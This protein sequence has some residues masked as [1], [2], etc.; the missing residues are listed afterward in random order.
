MDPGLEC[1]ILGGKNQLRYSL[2]ACWQP[3][4]LPITSEPLTTLIR[5]FKLNISSPAVDTCSSLHRGPT[6]HTR[7]K[8]V[9]HESSAE[10]TQSERISAVYTTL[11]RIDCITWMCI[12]RGKCS[13]TMILRFNRNHPWPTHRCDIH[14]D[15]WVIIKV[16]FLRDACL[17]L[18]SLLSNK[19][20]STN[21]PFQGTSPSPGRVPSPWT[22]HWHFWPPEQLLVSWCLQRPATTAMKDGHQTLLESIG[23][24]TCMCK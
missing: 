21:C 19:S 13:K 24:N 18:L 4:S 16:R 17:S 15:L 9:A 1:I 23:D 8:M 14:S 10:R 6:P 20:S 22:W 7:T 11:Y 2:T 3:Q 12:P 5:I